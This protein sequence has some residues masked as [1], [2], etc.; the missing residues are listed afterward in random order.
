MGSDAED[1]VAKRYPEGGE[2]PF[3]LK[4][5]TWTKP[6]VIEIQI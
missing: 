1:K 5:V 6:G 3:V 4:S 2:I